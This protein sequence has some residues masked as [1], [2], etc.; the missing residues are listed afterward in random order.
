L[1][2]AAASSA[3]RHPLAQA[4]AAAAGSQNIALSVRQFVSI[5]GKCDRRA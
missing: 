4:I 2:V 5:A 1:R 3:D